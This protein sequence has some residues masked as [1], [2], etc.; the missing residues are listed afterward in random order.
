MEATAGTTDFSVPPKHAHLTYL[1][2]CEGL[3][4]GDIVLFTGRSSLF[5]CMIR[6]FQAPLQW[7]HIGLIFRDPHDQSLWLLQS[8]N[9]HIPYNY[10]YDDTRPWPKRGVKLSPLLDAM[11][12]YEGYT[13]AV[14]KMLHSQRNN[15]TFKNRIWMELKYFMDK[16]RDKDYEKNWCELFGAAFKMN[17]REDQSSFFCTELV[18][19]F[20]M[21]YDYISRERLSN[22]YNLWDFSSSGDLP[23]TEDFNY[24]E[25]IYYYHTFFP[26]NNKN[27]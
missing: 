18:A 15:Y 20:Y 22:N 24:S 9:E 27:T 7:T 26:D 8:N 25:E 14:R 1:D 5:S 11:N 6:C 10:Y 12:S 13:I 16:H 4:S 21:D 2:I 19:Q 3:E 17:Q 23:W